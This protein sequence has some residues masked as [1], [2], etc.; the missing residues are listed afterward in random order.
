LRQRDLIAIQNRPV[1][2]PGWQ[3]GNRPLDD[4]GWKL[5]FPDGIDSK[6]G[7][8]EAKVQKAYKVPKTE[9]P[10]FNPLWKT[11]LTDIEIYKLIHKLIP[12]LQQTR[13]KLN[14]DRRHEDSIIRSLVV[15][16][17]PYNDQSANRPRDWAPFCGWAIAEN[18]YV[19]LYRQRL[20]EGPAGSIRL[21]FNNILD[22]FTFSSH[23]LSNLDSKFPW[24]DQLIVKNSEEVLKTSDAIDAETVA[25]RLSEHDTFQKTK[26]EIQRLINIWE[27]SPL[28]HNSLGGK[29]TIDSQISR[30]LDRL[31][32]V[33]DYIVFF[34]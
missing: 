24:C 25:T 14:A 6:K 30:S 5:L 28:C 33:C 9:R 23:R 2:D 7:I 29:G 15:T 19:K 4:I 11:G 27:N 17:V 1:D 16:S 31:I 3:I 10:K 26:A 22:A 21:S 18:S 8:T 20:L 13:I 32:S 12:T 34:V